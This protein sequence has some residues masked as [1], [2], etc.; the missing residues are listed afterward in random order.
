MPKS[1]AVKDFKNKTTCDLISLLK[2]NTLSLQEGTQIVT[3]ILDRLHKKID[4]SA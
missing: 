1:Q 3:E 2:S 4:H